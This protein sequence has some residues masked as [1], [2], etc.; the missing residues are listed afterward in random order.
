MTTSGEIT[1]HELV[2]L[3][4][5]YLD[6]VMAP[7]DRDRLDAHL[8]RCKP[9]QNYLQQMRTTIQT[10]G[11]LPEDSIS[12]DAERDLLAVFRAWKQG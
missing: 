1:C 12:P 11:T 9:C 3:V 7:A 6:D 10:V 2:G 8:S 5:E 4:T